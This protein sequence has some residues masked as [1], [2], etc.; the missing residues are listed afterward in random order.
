MNRLESKNRCRYG[1][2]I[3]M[4]E[5]NLFDTGYVWAPYVPVMETP[6]IVMGVDSFEPS[7]GIS[8][9]YS[10]A[11]LDTRFYREINLT[12]NNTIQDEGNRTIL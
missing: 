4:M 8:S 10:T 3:E 7:R 2:L 9:R 5:T 1:L 12:P 6:Q 11:M